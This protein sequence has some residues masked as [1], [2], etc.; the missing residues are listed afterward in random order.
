[1]R[2]EHDGDYALVA[3][4]GGAPTHPFWYHNLT[5]DPEVLIQ[6]GPEPVEMTVHLASGRGAGA[7]VG[8]GRRGL[9]VLRGLPDQDRPRDPGLRRG[10]ADASRRRPRGAARPG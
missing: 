6:D 8:A 2:V 1:M 5:A 9:P 4:K 3:S 10:A 7:L